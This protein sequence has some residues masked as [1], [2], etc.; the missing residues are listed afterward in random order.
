MGQAVAMRRDRAAGLTIQRS[1]FA[2]FQFP[3]EVITVAARW[4]LRYV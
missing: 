1:A 3:P 2:G 4:Y